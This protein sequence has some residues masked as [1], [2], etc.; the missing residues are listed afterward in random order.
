[1]AI[2]LGSFFD[3]MYS[4]AVEL[5]SANAGAL[6]TDGQ[7]LAGVLLLITLAWIVVVWALSSNGVTAMMDAIGVITRYSIVSLLL[8]GWVGTVGGFFQS[9]A[10]DLAQRLT[11]VRSVSE[12]VNLMM[13]G[14]GRLLVGERIATECQDTSSAGVLPGQVAEAQ[15]G[16]SCLNKAGTHATTASWYDILVDLPMVFVTW[17]LRLVAL[18][19]MGLFLAAYL[20]VIF[21][22]EILFGLGLTLGAVLVPWLIWKRTEWLF[23]GWLKFMVA[24]S[25]TKVVAAFMVMATASLVMGVKTFSEAVPTTTGADLI[26]VD[27]ITAFLLCVICAMGTYLMWQV[28]GIASSLMNGGSISVSQFGAG[29]HS[30]RLNQMAAKQ[31]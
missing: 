4:K 18:L 26:A 10:N 20:S 30:R 31:K 22:A 12:T 5:M 15:V 25:L 23:D 7:D 27:E 3:D 1:M 9:N 14:A 17:L 16:Q 28:P 13:A 6:V 29:T 24:S 11:G 8:A 2:A 19:M 21:M